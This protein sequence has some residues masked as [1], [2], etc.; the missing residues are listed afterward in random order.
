MKL[1]LTKTTWWTARARPCSYISSTLAC[2]AANTHIAAQDALALAPVNVG[3]DNNP[4]TVID[5]AWIALANLD[6]ICKSKSM[7]IVDE[8]YQSDSRSTFGYFPPQLQDT[9]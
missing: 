7:T 5:V 6:N 2:S 8:L 9:A 3:E 4:P 1:P